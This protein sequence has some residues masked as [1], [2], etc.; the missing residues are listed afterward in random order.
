[1]ASDVQTNGGVT[2]INENEYFTFHFYFLQQEHRS[3]LLGLDTVFQDQCISSSIVDQISLPV[4][5]EL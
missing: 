3:L 1:M 4:L 2:I 5:V